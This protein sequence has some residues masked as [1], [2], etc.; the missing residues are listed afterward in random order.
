MSDPLA[1]NLEQPASSRPPRILLFLTLL[2]AGAVLAGLLWLGPGQR[3]SPSVTRHL[4]FGAAEQSY[5]PAI[6]VEAIT[7][8]RTENYLHQEVTTVKGSLVNSGDRALRGVEL[9]LEFQDDMRQVVLRHT[10]VSVAPQALAARSSRDLEVSLEHIPDSW[11]RQAPLT[12][13][14][15]LEFE[16]SR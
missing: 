15:G 14:I 10:F 9:N 12:H 8:E 5:A 6:R 4:P 11:N 16:P 13:V 1:G 7:L 3:S 2:L